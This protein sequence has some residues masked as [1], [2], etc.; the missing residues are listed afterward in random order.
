MPADPP[1]VS[2]SRPHLS[3]PQPPLLLI[4]DRRQVQTGDVIGVVASACAA[5]CRWVSLR[6][7]DLSPAKQLALFARL[8]EVAQPFGVTLTLHGPGQLALDAGADG[9]HLPAGSDARAARTLLGPEAL[10]GL[11]LHDVAEIGALPAGSVDYVTASPVFLSASKPGY[12]PALGAEGLARFVAA[13]CLSASCAPV[14]ALGGIGA[15]QVAICRSAGASG[16]AVMGDVMR[17][18]TPAAHIETLIA[19]LI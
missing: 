6:E 19:S 7:K 5:G 12:G 17:A 11:S 14:V 3:L 10:I 4:T 16:V 15:E 9:V 18:K 8:R 1:G 2:L 13:S